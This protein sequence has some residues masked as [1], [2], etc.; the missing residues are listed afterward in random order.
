MAWSLESNR[1]SFE[2][3]SIYIQHSIQHSKHPYLIY[4]L[5]NIVCCI[6]C[7][8]TLF[9][10]A[11]LSFRIKPP[12]STR[13]I[14]YAIVVY[15]SR[16]SHV[17]LKSF[18]HWAIPD[19]NELN[20]KYRTQRPQKHPHRSDVEDNKVGSWKERKCRI[21]PNSP[22]LCILSAIYYTSPEIIRKKTVYRPTNGSDMLNKSPINPIGLICTLPV[23][24]NFNF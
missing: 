13:A 6:P 17:L 24:S 3:L 18:K 21:R 10:K 19:P 22:T 5:H 9:T 11:I 15:F 4:C 2:V 7:L 12:T 14:L 20:S 8:R 23:T 16:F 1:R